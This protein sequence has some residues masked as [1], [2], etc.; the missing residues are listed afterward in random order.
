MIDEGDFPSIH[1]KMSLR[2]LKSVRKVDG[3]SLTFID[4]YVPAP[5]PHLNS[6]E[7]SLQLLENVT[8]FVVCCICT[9]VILPTVPSL[10]SLTTDHIE[11]TTSKNSSIIEWCNGLLP[12]NGL[13]I[14]DTGVYFGCSENVYRPLRSGG[15]LFLLNCSD[16][17][18]SYHS[19]V[20]PRYTSLI[21][22]RSLDLYQ[23]NFSHKK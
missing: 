1:C 11:N 23:T 12:S 9:G 10:Y 15:R 20:V 8:L 19:T 6:S 21:R 7:I 16:F 22:S 4:F 14:V 3:L 18:S 2:R 17:Q 13:G 5:T